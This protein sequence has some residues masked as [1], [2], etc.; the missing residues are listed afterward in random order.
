MC[1]FQN[2]CKKNTINKIMQKKK[3]KML[4]KFQL[5]GWFGIAVAHDSNNILGEISVVNCLSKFGTVF[6]NHPLNLKPHF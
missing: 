5:R 6:K 2:Y 4:N 3:S 1:L